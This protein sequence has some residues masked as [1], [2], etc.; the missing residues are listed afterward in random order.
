MRV[1]T[2]RN[3]EP[4]SPVRPL[5]HLLSDETTR[6]STV[7]RRNPIEYDRSL[8][9]DSVVGSVKVTFLEKSDSSR[10]RFVKGVG[11]WG[12]RLRGN[13]FQLDG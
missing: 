8:S 11:V 12:G 4:R 3:E 10:C 5:I 6:P 1:L 13:S 9:S 2:R 7:L